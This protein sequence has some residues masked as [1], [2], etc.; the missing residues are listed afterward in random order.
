LAPTALLAFAKVGGDTN[1]FSYIAYFLL[2]AGLMCLAR[3]AAR[4]TLTLAT[5]AAVALAIGNPADLVQRVRLITSLTV[6]P[7]QWAYQLSREHP[8]GIYFP[9]NTLSTL[10]SDG[11]LYHFD[12]GIADRRLAGFPPSPQ[13]LRAGMPAKMRLIAIPTSAPPAETRPPGVEPIHSPQL[14]GYD[15]YVVSP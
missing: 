10:L 7:Q 1:N 11:K 8:E 12:A 15:I 13:H 6:N 3:I 5:A 9:W 2:A 4:V 14:P